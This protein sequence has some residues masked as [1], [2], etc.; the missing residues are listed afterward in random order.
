MQQEM[1][2]S[3]RV[4]WYV[5]LSGLAGGQLVFNLSWMFEWWSAAQL[6][7]GGLSVVAAMWIGVTRK[8]TWRLWS[9]LGVLVAIGQW[10]L[11]R[12]AWTLLAWSCRG[13]GP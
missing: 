7:L 10:H 9:L 13:F 11:L 1:N 3:G 8:A 2:T 12:R 6:V 5:L 4:A